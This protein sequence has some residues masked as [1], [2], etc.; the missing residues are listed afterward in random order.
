MPKLTNLELAHK[1]EDVVDKQSTFEKYIKGKFKDWTPKIN[2]MH[3]YLVGQEEVE[4]YKLTSRKSIGVSEMTK[5]ILG[6]I[7]FLG[8]I[9][10]TIILVVGR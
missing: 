1:I 4:K 9:G 10:S 8:V 3:D 2:A 5:I 7:S 6:I